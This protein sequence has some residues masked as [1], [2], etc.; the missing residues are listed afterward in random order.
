MF[1]FEFQEN[2]SKVYFLDG[3]NT[4]VWVKRGMAGIA[5]VLV[6]RQESPTSAFLILWEEK[7]V[8]LTGGRKHLL[9]GRLATLT[10]KSL[11]CPAG[12]SFFCLNK[13]GLKPHHAVS[14]KTTWTSPT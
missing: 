7:S 11:D 5:G 9:K 2:K 14:K 1:L 6:R 8:T 10:G 13:S 3:K 4:F 12:K